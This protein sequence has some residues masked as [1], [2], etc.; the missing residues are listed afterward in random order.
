MENRVL[1]E[2]M[3]AQEIF[4]SMMEGMPQVSGILMQMFYDDAG[5]R[6]MFFCDKINVRGARLFDLYNKCCKGDFNIFRRTLVMIKTGVYSLDEVNKNLDLDTPISFVVDQ[7]VLP[8]MPIYA[9]THEPNE[10]GWYQYC[11][12][13]RASFLKRLETASKEQSGP[14]KELKEA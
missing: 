8:D 2:N 14:K 4:S 3:N 12:M 6:N 13:N 10:E 9:E 11:I 1:N 5:C 7:V